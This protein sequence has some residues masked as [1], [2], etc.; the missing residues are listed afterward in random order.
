MHLFTESGLLKYSTECAPNG[1]YFIP[2]YDMGSFYLQIEG[3]TGW[4]FEPF[5]V[6]IAVTEEEK[7][8]SDDINFH[9]TGFSLL[10]NVA[11]SAADDCKVG[12]GGPAG[13]TMSLFAP[14]E[15]TPDAK[16]TELVSTVQ[17]V[18]GGNFEFTNVSPG[19]YRIVASHD[20]WQFA[21][22]EQESVTE[23]G[24]SELS[25]PFRLGGY[26]LTGSI[27][28]SGE[29]ISGVDLFLFS[30]TA[31]DVSCTAPAA[32]TVL[33]DHA[34]K[35]LCV[36]NSGADGQYSFDNLPCGEY[37]LVPSHKKTN[38]KFD[39]SPEFLDVSLGHGNALVAEPFQ[40]M[41]FS[42]QGRVIDVSS[43]GLEGATI[44]LNGQDKAVTRADGTYT[45]ERMTT[46]KYTITARKS[47]M[48]FHDLK[49]FA[50]SPSVPAVPDI[51]VTRYHICGKVDSGESTPHSVALVGKSNQMKADTVTDKSGNY[52]FE[53]APGTYQVTPSLQDAE[54]AK[55]I[56]LSPPSREVVISDKPNLA[57]NFVQAMVSLKG[58]VKC[59]NK[60]ASNTRVSIRLM[61]SDDEVFQTVDKNGAFSFDNVFPGKYQVEVHHKA[62]CWT[63]D[64]VVVEVEYEDVDN[65]EFVQSGFV[66]EGE[67]SHDAQVAVYKGSE[68]K[69]KVT[70]VRGRNRMCVAESGS[71]RVVPESCYRFDNEEY[72]FNT[73][74]PKVL[75][76][77][78]RDFRVRGEIFVE[79]ENLD[80]VKIPVQVRKTSTSAAE[81]RSLHATY[82][83][84]NPA[85]DSSKAVR[86]YEYVY[87][88]SPGDKFE[89]KPVVQLKA[90]GEINSIL[91]YPRMG[92]IALDD[93]EC[94]PP[95]SPFHGRVG[96]YLKGTVHPS[97]SMAKL[98]VESKTSGSILT[99]VSNNDGSYAAGPLYD[100]EDYSIK[101]QGEG[102][103]FKETS[104]GNFRALKLGKIN[105]MITEKG[106]GKEIPTPEVMLSLGGDDYQQS[107]TTDETGRS[108]FGGLFP[109]K[110]FL[111]PLLKEFKFEPSSK[112]IELD[113]AGSVLE[114][115]VAIRVAYSAYGSVRS[116]NGAP[117]KDSKVEATQI[118]DSLYHEDGTRQYPRYEET[119]TDADGS[120]R[121]KG[122]MPNSKY[123]IKIDSANTR[124]DRSSPNSMEV[125]VETKDITALNFV[126]FRKLSMF[127]LTGTLNSSVSED[128]FKTIEV[129]L[130][131]ASKPDKVIKTARVCKALPFFEFKA[132]PEDKYVVYARSSLPVRTYD[133]VAPK[134]TATVEDHTHVTVD[135]DAQFK[136]QDVQEFVQGSL[137]QLILFFCASFCILNKDMV[138][139]QAPGI[140]E[141][142]ASK[143]LSLANGP[144]AKKTSKKERQLNRNSSRK[145]RK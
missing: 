15:G 127:D 74:T 5:R 111:R 21:V 6:P 69:E 48:F 104:P 132:L 64:S 40:V 41:G 83:T 75:E 128:N 72:D 102:Y 65:I 16:A 101:A 25:E 62:W 110:Y 49:E 44:S 123:L 113:Q 23:W 92:T 58:R 77:Q 11:G 57:T 143:V 45:L 80:A 27:M 119:D 89:I 10:G 118:L 100:D 141:G 145:S 96:L 84:T 19:K 97:G 117:E 73:A 99:V 31:K 112:S 29:P 108:S 105:V 63:K 37:T 8:C 136:K 139:Q 103:H 66:L 55:G 20:K 85:T 70:L 115:F 93:E 42:I 78:A 17:T 82:V 129:V 1:Y 14:P 137:F 88:A 3:P 18:D 126:A 35:A 81:T 95:A 140:I 114:S 138:L 131:S 50:L 38:T 90:K 71:Y 24:N 79:A 60:C 30:K 135:F 34:G 13:V 144:V 2:V 46:G 53:A 142:V 122:L 116:L 68:L 47:H 22:A 9:F 125:Q 56:Y 52:C 124:I 7:G 4:A 133:F 54:I 121:L 106:T 120:F 109:G 61:S 39:V 86:V 12:G 91:F 98:V 36:I 87:W 28:A 94:P 134:V 26:Q 32:G 59:L 130:A 33:P 51:V 107:N 43:N 67:L 76:L